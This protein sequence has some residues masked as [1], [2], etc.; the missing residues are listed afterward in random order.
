MLCRWG[1]M[2]MADPPAALRETRRVLRPGGRVALAVWDRLEHNP[3]MMLP[4]QEL[5]ER[6]LTEPPSAG[7]PGPF[8]LGDPERVPSCSSRR[9]SSRCASR[10]SSC[11]VATRASRSSGTRRSTSR[12]SST[13]RCSIAPRPRSPRSMRRSSSASRPTPRLT[14]R[15]TFPGARSWPSAE[16]LSACRRA[17]DAIACAPM[18]YDD[19]ADLTLLDGKTVAII[20]YGS[21]GHAHALNL[22]DS[23]VESRRRAARG[24]RL[25]RRRARAGP[26]GAVRRRGRQPRRPRDD[27]AARRAPPR[28]LGA[29]DPRRHRRGQHAAVRPRLLDPLQRD[30]AAAGR[31]RRH[32]RAQGARASRAPAVPRRQRRTRP[33]RRRAGRDSATPAG[34]RWPTRRGSAARAAA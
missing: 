23:G 19:D 30:R 24:L 17:A 3:W 16:R 8:V 7:T 34:W 9:A 1:Y 13:T 28:R 12:A 11:T 31:R 18:L 33:R 21:Q 6:G 4:A 15:S 10:R 14:A 25:R 32:G 27:P 20:G 2:L 22:K 5:R 26:R 29:R